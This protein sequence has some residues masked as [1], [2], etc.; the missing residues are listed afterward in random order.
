MEGRPC[1]TQRTQSPPAGDLSCCPRGQ[2]LEKGCRREAGVISRPRRFPV[3]CSLTARLRASLVLSGKESA[4]QG[5]RLRFHPWVGKLPWR[6]KWQPPP[7]FLP[8]ESYG[9]RN[10]A[11][12]SPWGQRTVGPDLAA[13]QQQ[14]A[15]AEV[16]SDAFLCN[17]N[18]RN[19]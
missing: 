19:F 15:R 18:L 6:R 1:V 13:K 5:K 8:G 16:L 9:Q 3:R 2:G 14:T 12:L 11:G 4:C 7:V 10:L 17:W